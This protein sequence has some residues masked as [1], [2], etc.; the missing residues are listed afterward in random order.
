LDL[1]AV[2]GDEWGQ[3]RDGCIKWGVEV[4]EGKGSFGSK[5]GASY[6]N[7]WGLGIVILCHEWWRCSSSQITVGFF[8][9]VVTGCCGC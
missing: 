7:H 8:V 1:D 6:C 2:W 9:V 3:S 5:Y 4:I